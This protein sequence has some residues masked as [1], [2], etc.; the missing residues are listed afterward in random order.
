MNTYIHIHI[1]IYTDRHTHIYIYIYIY[2]YKHGKYNSIRKYTY[3]NMLKINLN[4]NLNSLQDL[5]K[6]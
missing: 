2:I 5:F 6:D 1:C 4:S 3:K